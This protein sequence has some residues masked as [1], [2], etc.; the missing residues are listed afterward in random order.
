MVLI[1]VNLLPIFGVIYANWSVLEIVA[2]YWF[3]NI[4]IGSL[5]V[6]KILTCCPSLELSDENKNCPNTSIHPPRAGR[7]TTNDKYEA[8][9]IN[10]QIS[11]ITHA[12]LSC[13]WR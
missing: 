3:E 9:P 6:L 1:L 5:N 8:E 13:F 2:L 10:T 11:L 4:V 7:F 12:N